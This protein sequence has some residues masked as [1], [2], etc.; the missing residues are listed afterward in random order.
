MPLVFN[1]LALF[2]S[3]TVAVTAWCA[4]AADKD[5]PKFS[6][7]PA[8]SYAAHQTNARITVGVDPFVEDE[9]ARPAF[10]KN[11]PYKYGVLPVL[12]VIQND[13]EKALRV[14]HLKVDYNGPNSRVE[15]TPAADVKFLT[16]PRRPDVMSGPTG[17][18]K[19]LK[20]KNPLTVGKSRAAPSPRA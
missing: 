7:A 12:V 11:S 20:R 16:G 6:A 17:K 8:A 9:K 19:V 14:D 1:R 3:I 13:T 4:A 15:A 2:L 10:G 5:S 18:P